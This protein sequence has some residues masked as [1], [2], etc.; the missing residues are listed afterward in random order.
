MRRGEQM[1]FRHHCNL[2]QLETS[3]KLLHRGENQ[4]RD[5]IVFSSGVQDLMQ[6]E[7]Y[8]TIKCNG[9]GSVSILVTSQSEAMEEPSVRSF[10][11]RT[12]RRKPS[13]LTEI[14]RESLFPRSYFAEI[15]DEIYIALQ[16][17]SLRLAVMGV[18][19]LLESAM[20]G[21]V[22]DQGNFKKNINKFEE[23]GFISKNQREVLEATI[24]AGHAV[25]HRRHTPEYTNV[26]R[27]MDLAESIIESVLVCPAKARLVAEM[28]PKR[29]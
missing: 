7:L 5:E 23:A 8:D 16:N 19:A 22:G 14:P 18:R 29:N 28:T 26:V 21:K 25:M 6:K 17:G 12:F 24:E 1:E 13:W 20:I 15:I 9:C 3:H 27:L 2:C 11:P 10:P 4:W